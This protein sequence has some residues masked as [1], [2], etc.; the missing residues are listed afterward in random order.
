M[1]DLV[2]IVVITIVAFALMSL[3]CSFVLSCTVTSCKIVCLA[4][5]APQFPNSY[6]LAT[7]LNTEATLNSLYLT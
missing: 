7:N 4:P 1:A 3:D 5:L 2:G 6:I